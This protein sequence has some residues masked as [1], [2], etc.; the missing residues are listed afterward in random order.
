MSEVGRSDVG[1]VSLVAGAMVSGQCRNVGKVSE[2][3][4]VAEL[5]NRRGKFELRTE[6]LHK[7]KSYYLE[8]LSKLG[9]N[10]GYMHARKES[11]E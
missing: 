1:A 8:Q 4:W 9:A 3:G 11:L 2:V 5:C 6:A 10:N 7:G